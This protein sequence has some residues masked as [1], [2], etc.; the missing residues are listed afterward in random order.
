MSVALAHEELGPA[1]G[2]VVVLA[3]SIG[4]SRIVWRAV[5]DEL[6]ARDGAR[7]VLFDHRGHGESPIPDGPYALSD[8][9]ADLVALLDRLEIPRAA[10]AGVSLGGMVAMRAALDAPDRVSSLVL[11]C[12]SAHMPPRSL[13]DERAQ[14]AS[15]EGMGPLIE[16]IIARWVAPGYEERD[17]GAYTRL[18]TVLAAT[19]PDG[20]ASTALAIRDMDLRD[21]LPNIA[22]PTLVLVGSE[23]Q[24]TPAEGHGELLAERIPDARLATIA[25]AAHLAPYERPAEVAAHLRDHLLG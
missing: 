7:V 6:V 13:W 22:A 8:L 21:E 2:P 18:R 20:Y 17:P 4:T 5:A 15:T 24:A 16:G 10:V 12:T 1:D 14:T 11:C 25:D 3:H 9:A 19:P 23:D